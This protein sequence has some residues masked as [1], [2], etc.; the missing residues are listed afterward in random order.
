MAQDF[1]SS[2]KGEN[3][4]SIKSADVQWL[5]LRL[6]TSSIARMKW[7]FFRWNLINGSLTY[8]LGLLL[9]KIL[10]VLLRIL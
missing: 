6:V 9:R 5:L 7:T 10:A 1:V 8:L 3:E 4:H 2:A